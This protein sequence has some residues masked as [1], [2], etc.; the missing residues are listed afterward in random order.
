MRKIIYYVASSLDGYIAGK[1]DD[2]SKFILQGEGVEK[3]RSDVANFRTVIMGR[4][5]YEFGFQY[6]LKP[7]QPAYP[8]M[9]NHI[10][11]NSIKIDNLSEFV[12]IE[13]L[14]VDRVKEIRENANTDIYLCGGGEFAGWLLDNGLID[15]LK[16]KLNPVVLGN[17]TKLFGSSTTNENWVLTET[18][19]FLDGLQILTYDKKK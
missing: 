5:T 10:F 19:S 11:S 3:Y 14:S 9:E 17:G 6:G 4:K 2:I 8:N 18:E 1:N 12:K 13:K 15:Q 16:L 7:G